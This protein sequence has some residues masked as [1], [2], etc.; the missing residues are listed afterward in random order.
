MRRSLRDGRSMQQGGANGSGRD[1]GPEGRSVSRMDQSWAEHRPIGP[2]SL[3]RLG[4]VPPI[5]VTNV[6]FRYGTCRR[7]RLD[8][9]AST[10]GARRRR[11][12]PCCHGARRSRRVPARRYRRR[13]SRSAPCRRFECHGAVGE[14]QCGAVLRDLTRRGVRAERPGPDPPRRPVRRA[15]LA[16]QRA[17][18]GGRHSDRA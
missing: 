4:P 6:Q 15:A 11:Q 8:G 1:D 13:A 12:R 14:P 16:H 17:G 5:W 3:S 2:S 18:Q 9:I 10:P 7:S